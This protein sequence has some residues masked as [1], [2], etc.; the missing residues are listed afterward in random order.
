DRL[1][2][3]WTSPVYAFYLPEPEIGYDDSGVDRRPFHDFVCANKGCNKRIRRYLDK[4]D[5]KAT[6]NLGKHARRCWKSNVVDAA[7][8][9]NGLKE[10][11]EVIAGVRDGT[12]TSHFE[13]TGQGKET[14]SNVQLS[15][16][17]TSDRGL[18]FLMKTGRPHYY[19]PSP[20]TVS[21]DVRLIFAR[22]RQRIAAMLQKYEG[23]L[24]FATDAWTSPNHRAYVAITVHLVHNGRPL[25]MVLDIVQVA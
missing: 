8:D 19:L 9:A 6:G 3:H 1:R 23:R 25:S 24:S 21:R 11:R 7:F 15:K 2:R 17:E 18:K 22:T 5:A 12:I 13:R 10:A 16:A 14:Y 4:G 20:W